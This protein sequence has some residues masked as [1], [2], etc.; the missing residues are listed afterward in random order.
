RRLPQHSGGAFVVILH[1]GGAHYLRAANPTAYADQ[2]HQILVAVRLHG[3]FHLFVQ[4][5]PF[6]VLGELVDAVAATE[7][8]LTHAERFG[9]FDDVGPDIFDLLAILRFDR[10]ETIGNQPAEVKRDLRAVAIGR[11]NRAAILT[12]PIGLARLFQRGKE[13][14]RRRDTDG[15]IADSFCK[16]ICRK[17]RR[18][19]T[20]HGTP[21]EQKRGRNTAPKTVHGG[22]R[23]HAGQ[24]CQ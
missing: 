5:V 14:S 15:I 18:F 20:Y 9:E 2:D 22:K 21:A 13:F 17:A 1:D 11:W 24:D 12:G 4:R 16:L 7:H 23:T 8:V 19:R 10:D 3:G 6:A